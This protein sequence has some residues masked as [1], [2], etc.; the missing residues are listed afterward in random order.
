MLPELPFLLSAEVTPAAASEAFVPCPFTLGSN[1][2][3]ETAL[4]SVSDDGILPKS[5]ELHV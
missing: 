3:H 2:C 1:R 5:Q 4:M